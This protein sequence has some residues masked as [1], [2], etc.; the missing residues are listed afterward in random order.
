MPQPTM[1]ELRARRDAIR[2]ADGVDRT[3]SADQRRTEQNKKLL[4][5][6]IHPATRRPLLKAFVCGECAHHRAHRGNKNI[7]H[8]CE[9]HRLGLSRGAASDIRV[10]WPACDLFEAAS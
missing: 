10:G 6:G 3:L 4:S 8:K 9:L 1:D 5:L 7:F 2:E